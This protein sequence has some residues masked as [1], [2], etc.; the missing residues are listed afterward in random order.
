MN[1]VSNKSKVCSVRKQSLVTG[2]FH[3]CQFK[4]PVKI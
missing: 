2:L 1:P 4:K 3:N